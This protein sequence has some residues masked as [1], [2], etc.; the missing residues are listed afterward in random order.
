MISFTPEKPNNFD[1]LI[2]LSPRPVIGWNERRAIIATQEQYNRSSVPGM[3]I[4]SIGRKCKKASG[5]GG[6]GG[7]GDGMKIETNERNQWQLI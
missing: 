3:E 1:K 7:D 6:G 2:R 4:K 5:K